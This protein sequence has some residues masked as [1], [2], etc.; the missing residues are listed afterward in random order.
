MHDVPSLNRILG[1]SFEQRARNSISAPVLAHLS[2]SP[3]AATAQV[4]WGSTTCRAIG[5]GAGLYPTG[6]AMRSM[7]TPPGSKVT[8]T[9]RAWTV[10]A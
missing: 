8:K 4:E 7:T 10:G 2:S 6:A 3:A 5:N 1:V 9:T